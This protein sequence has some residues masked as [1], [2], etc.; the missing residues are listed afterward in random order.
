MTLQ[1][2]LYTTQITER[3]AA[4]RIQTYTRRYLAQIQLR[5]LLSE[6]ELREK[7]EA[8]LAASRVANL[9]RGQDASRR[10]AYRPN[11]D[12]SFEAM[13]AEIIRRE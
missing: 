10:L 1:R 11:E 5:L 13:K 4:L 9:K 12:R 8:E 2:R 6:K 3:A 7:R